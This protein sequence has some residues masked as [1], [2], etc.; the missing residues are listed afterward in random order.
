MFYEELEHVDRTVNGFE[1]INRLEQ[2]L[3]AEQ[4]SSNGYNEIRMKANEEKKRKEAEAAA[5]DAKASGGKPAE[6]FD[7]DGIPMSASAEKESGKLPSS[8]PSSP[9]STPPSGRSPLTP[10]V[11]K[12]TVQVQQISA[13]DGRR[14]N[15][16]RT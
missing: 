14:S 9:P 6:A 13:A 3:K 8:P 15:R 5:E 4:T 12:P 7:E 1:T 10:T 11:A 16:A 2:F